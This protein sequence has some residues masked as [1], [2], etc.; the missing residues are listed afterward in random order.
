MV[1]IFPT[2]GSADCL[3]VDGLEFE[4]IAKSV[5]LIS[6]QGKNLGTMSIIYIQE[7]REAKNFR[8]F[9]DI[10]CDSGAED[11]IMID[12]ELRRIVSIKLFKNK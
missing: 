8:F 9:T 7:A 5:F 3:K 12:G 2:F 10:I 1:L 11:Q 6:K 4:G